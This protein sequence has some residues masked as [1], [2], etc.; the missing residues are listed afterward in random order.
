[1]KKT[2]CIALLVFISF[3][4]SCAQDYRKGV[5]GKWNAGMATTEKDM[6]VTIRGDGTFTAE[7]MGHDMKPAPGTYRINRGRIYF[8][9][10]K[11]ELHY[12]IISLD[13]E[14]LVMSSKYARLTWH[15]VK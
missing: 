13:E 9:F 15:R 8:S 6:V 3:A 12:K 4:L 14:T 1:M 10:P 5:V 2:G 11:I 7:I